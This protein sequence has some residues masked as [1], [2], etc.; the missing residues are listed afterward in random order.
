MHVVRPQLEALESD[1]R[2]RRRFDHNRAMLDLMYRS[3]YLAS[4]ISESSAAEAPAAEP[5]QQVLAN[6]T[7]PHLIHA[8]THAMQHHTAHA[9]NDATKMRTMLHYTR[10]RER[11]FDELHS[12][13]GLVLPHEHMSRVSVQNE[14]EDVQ[15][16]MIHMNDILDSTNFMNLVPPHFVPDPPPAPVLEGLKAAHVPGPPQGSIEFNDHNH[17]Q[18]LELAKYASKCRRVMQLTEEGPKE[19]ARAGQNYATLF[20][21]RKGGKEWAKEFRRVDGEEHA[22]SAEKFS[23]TE[24]CSML[25]RREAQHFGAVLRNTHTTSRAL[26]TTC[27]PARLF[28]CGHYFEITVKT[29]FRSAAGGRPAFEPPALDRPAGLEVKARNEGLVLGVTTTKPSD[30]HK[31]IRCAHEVP[32]SWCIATNGRFYANN[33]TEAPLKTPRSINME[34]ITVVQPW[35]K[36]ADPSDPS[37]VT[38]PPPKG[39]HAKRDVD[40]SIAL[41]EGSTVGMLVTP[42]GGILITVDGQKELL[43]ADAGVPADQPLYPLVEVYNRVRSVRLQPGA[44]PQP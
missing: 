15:R 5:V 30:I 40:W 18:D 21:K 9:V 14:L 11:G 22:N 44:Q 24:G 37:L 25:V 39:S 10:E 28:T 8:T 31:A 17:A 6:S 29:I 7:V 23:L 42:W 12:G 1:P 19:I 32:M 41:E 16:S 20:W 3:E 33:S 4:Q 34:R 2:V 36:K 26:V 38:W 27:S 13:K 35:R 43:V